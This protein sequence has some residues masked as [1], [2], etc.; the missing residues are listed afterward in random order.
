MIAP[1]D[2]SFSPG[3]LQPGP[4]STT[5]ARLPAAS[6][7]L[8]NQCATIGVPSNELTTMS[9][10]CAEPASPAQASAV[11][12]IPLLSLMPGHPSW[13]VQGEHAPEQEDS[14]QGRGPTRRGLLG[15]A[16]ATGAGAAVP[17]AAAAGGGG[18]RHRRSADVV[19][20]GAGLAGLTTARALR[21]KG[22]SVVVLEARDRVGGRTWTK[23]VKGVPVDVGGQWIG[24]QQK[25]I[26]ALAE[27]VGVKTFPTYNKGLNVYD[28]LGT[29]KT[30]TGAIPPAET[31]AIADIAVALGAL[32]EMAGEVPLAAPWKAPRAREWDGQTLET[33]KLANMTT[34]EGRLLLDLGVEAVFAGEPRD[35]S[36]LHVLFYIHSAGSFDNLINTAGGA[37]ESRFVG[38]SQTGVPPRREGARI[39]GGAELARCGGSTSAAGTWWWSRTASRWRRAT[40]WSRRRRPWPAGSSITPRFRGGATSS[41]SGC[42]WARC[43]SAT[44]ST[45]S[46]SGVTTGAPARPRATR[47]R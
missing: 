17:A 4:L 28:R 14:R 25:R 21:K 34:E 13:E 44:R 27:G 26:A 7:G 36:L 16:V 29:L 24:P 19:V 15:G 41:P 42:R 35:V 45:T 22:H 37:Q 30:Y 11:T 23:Q 3:W 47:D 2:G 9:S 6:D 40:A 33:W 31:P 1:V 39:A 12:A 43:S 32:N 10:A 46:R 38:G 5:G 18:R 8:G 20:V